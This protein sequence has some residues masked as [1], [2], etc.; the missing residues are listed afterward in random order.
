MNPGSAG[1]SLF[2]SPESEMV[3][4]LNVVGEVD[5]SNAPNIYSLMWQ[6]SQKGSQ[7][8]ILNLEK[9]DFMDSS[10]LQVLLR[11]REKLRSKKQDV[12]LVGPRPQ[13]QKLLKLTGFDKIF[14]LAETNAQAKVLLRD[15]MTLAPSGQGETP[16]L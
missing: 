9:L 8:L 6:T 11:L 1:C 4:I 16:F 14:P 7:S 15:T 10:G 12:F 2:M 3:P 5:L 13:I